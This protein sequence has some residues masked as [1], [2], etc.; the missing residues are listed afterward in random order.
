MDITTTVVVE[1]AKFHILKQIFLE[2]FL[3]WLRTAL[4]KFGEFSALIEYFW[5]AWVRRNHLVN[6]N[7]SKLSKGIADPIQKS[8]F[9]MTGPHKL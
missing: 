3:L 9:N 1:S 6:R 5:L 4:G 2:L 8:L 7:F